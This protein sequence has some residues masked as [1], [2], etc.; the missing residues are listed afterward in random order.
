MFTRKHLLQSHRQATAH[1]ARSN[2]KPAGGPQEEQLFRPYHN[3]ALSLRHL[4]FVYRSSSI[5][6][7]YIQE[8]IYSIFLFSSKPN[9]CSSPRISLGY[10]FQEGELGGVHTPQQKLRLAGVW[11]AA[12]STAARARFLSVPTTAGQRRSEQTCPAPLRQLHG[13]HIALGRGGAAHGPL[14]RAWGGWAAIG[15]FVTKTLSEPA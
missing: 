4:H 14:A 11:S 6:T 13:R 3:Q 8:Y 7:S 9:C 5:N 10:A 12:P 2:T 15:C 1:G